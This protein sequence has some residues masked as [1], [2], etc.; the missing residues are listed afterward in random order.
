MP[1]IQVRIR[2]EVLAL[3]NGDAEA[4]LLPPVAPR[5]LATSW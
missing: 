3:L 2:S 5:R 1:D 4:P